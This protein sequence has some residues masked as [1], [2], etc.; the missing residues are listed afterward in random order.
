MTAELE[1]GTGFPES[2]VKTGRSFV[3][4]ARRDWADE[5]RLPDGRRGWVRTIDGGDQTNFYTYLPPDAAHA[6]RLHTAI[7]FGWDEAYAAKHARW[8]YE[9]Y[10]G[11]IARAIAEADDATKAKLR[12]AA[13]AHA[14]SM[15][16]MYS[17][18]EVFNKS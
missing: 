4:D 1:K 17:V 15:R 13:A 12:Q 9:C 6:A 2:Y 14:P 11:D 3:I 16:D 18:N 7:V 10:R 8:N 5:I